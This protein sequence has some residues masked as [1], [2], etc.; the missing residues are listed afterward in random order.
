MI[1]TIIIDKFLNEMQRLFNLNGR[2]LKQDTRL[3]EDL[4]ATPFHYS[5]MISAISQ[6]TGKTVSFGDIS[7]CKTMGEVIDLLES[8]A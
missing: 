5:E 1:D 6:M 4:Y 8:F 3:I 7:E 2:Q